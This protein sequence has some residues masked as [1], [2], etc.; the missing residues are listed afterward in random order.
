MDNNVLLLIHPA[1]GGIATLSALWVFVDTLNISE[2]SLARIK[3][4]SIL[5][6][7]LMW[8][9][10][11]IGGFWYVVYYAPEKAIILGGPWPFA[12]GFFMETKEHVFL[13]LLLLA[14][15]LPIAASSNLAKSK[16]A[17]KIVLWVAGLIVP[18][19][20]SM[21]GSGAIL[22]IAVKIGLLFKQAQGG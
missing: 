4:V 10:Y 3:N 9:T 15:Y 1:L 7:V 6:A 2:A 8:L 12:H 14:T 18:I 13:M 5:C 19:S 11:F 22:S 21:E 17:R 20:L 16:A